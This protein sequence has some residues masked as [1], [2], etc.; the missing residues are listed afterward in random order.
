LDKRAS[1]L[2]SL[3]SASIVLWSALGFSQNT[4]TFSI[5]D[6]RQI[7]RAVVAIREAILK[8]DLKQLLRQISSAGLTC[9][10]TGYSYKMI[11]AFL[12]DKKSHLYMSLFDSAR[13]SQQCGNEYPVQHPAIS[14]REFLRTADDSMSI[15]LADRNWARVTLTSPNPRHYSREW[16]FHREGG[17]WKVAGGSWVVGRCGCG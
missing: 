16:S 17:T 12:T 3:I 13:F 10:D 15:V 14:E 1:K 7:R 8:E 5:A 2:L 6:E 4:R 9:T 11:R